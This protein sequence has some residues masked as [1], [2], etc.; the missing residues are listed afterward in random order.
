MINIRHIDHNL[1]E[2]VS[3]TVLI[4][5]VNV[6]ITLAQSVIV[7]QVWDINY[8]R[9]VSKDVVHI[10]SIILLVGVALNVRENDYYRRLL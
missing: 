2:S 9:L 5:F 7:V 8:M 1:W 10:L 3:A 6:E 4:M